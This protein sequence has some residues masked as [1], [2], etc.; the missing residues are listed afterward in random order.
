MSEF[1]IRPHA[2][3]FAACVKGVNLAQALSA[4][5]AEQIRALWL[6][7]QV[8]YF[9]DQALTLSLIHI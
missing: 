8:L 9:P 4:A 7:Y 2:N 6:R 3:D 5:D 1:C